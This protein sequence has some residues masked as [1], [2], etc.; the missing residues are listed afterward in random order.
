MCTAV[1]YYVLLHNPSLKSLPF[2]SFS[3]CF[4]IQINGHLEKVS[5]WSQLDSQQTTPL[6]KTWLGTFCRVLNRLLWFCSCTVRSKTQNSRWTAVCAQIST[7][8]CGKTS[9]SYPTATV[10]DTVRHG[11]FK[12][13]YQYF[14]NSSHTFYF[15][16]FVLPV[17]T[18]WI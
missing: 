17:S 6:W 16:T 18:F 15:Q 12:G 9:I 11:F 1:N 5:C 14:I 13:S 3:T 8:G 4:F 2:F 7:K 10:Q